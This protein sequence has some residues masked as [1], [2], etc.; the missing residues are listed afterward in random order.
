MRRVFRLLSALCVV[1][2]ALGV[3]SAQAAF[4]GQNGKIAFASLPVDFSSAP[5]IWTISPNGADQTNLTGNS[6]AAEEDPKWSAD[7]RRLAFTSDR[8][9]ATN[10]DG[11]P[12]VFVMNADG[13]HVTQITFNRGEDINPTWSPDGRKIAFSRLP[14]KPNRGGYSREIWTINADGTGERQLTNRPGPDIEPNWSPDGRRI[15][16]S[17]ARDNKT[18]YLNIFTMDPNGGDVRQLTFTEFD[19]Q[20]PN[21]SPDG[22]QIAF[23]SDLPE[24]AIAG[25]FN[26]FTIR[27]DGSHLTRLT[28]EP[29]AGHPAWSPDGRQ[30]AF[31]NDRTGDGEIWTM[32]A[33]GS[34]QLRLTMRPLTHDFDPDW[35][36]LP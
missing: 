33:D 29:N 12:E 18:K 3:P 17:S 22:S 35:Q 16:F 4:P 36:P 2:L 6:P 25:S 24:G 7:G 13:S 1:G 8:V 31:G 11:D 32:L 27:S 26:V 15:A 30:I 34:Q 14:H 5:D 23:H 21:W 20:R 28:S 9:T 10:P 19:A